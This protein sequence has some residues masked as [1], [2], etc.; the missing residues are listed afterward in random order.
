MNEN[1]TE[2]NPYDVL[3]QHEEAIANI[4]LNFQTL[5]AAFN[6]HAETIDG[7]ADSIE[8]LAATQANIAETLALMADTLEMINNK[9]KALSS[10]K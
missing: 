6:D 9:V 1:N 7:H 10:D 3:V 5:G 2:F 8:D 4:M